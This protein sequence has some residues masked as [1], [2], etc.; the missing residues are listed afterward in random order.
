MA[1]L[2]S[3]AEKMALGLSLLGD[4]G[5]SSAVTALAVRLAFE[6]GQRIDERAGD[7]RLRLGT[8]FARLRQ[9]TRVRLRVIARRIEAQ[10]ARG[11]WSRFADLLQTAAGGFSALAAA[12]TG[13]GAGLVSGALLAG[14]AICAAN[15]SDAA[16]G[17][18]ALGLALAGGLIGLGTT[19]LQEPGPLG[20][21]MKCTAESLVWAS[22]GGATTGS[23]AARLAAADEV[24]ARATLLGLEATIAEGQAR[25]RR[26]RQR[27]EGLQQQMHRNL[28]GLLGII[29][30]D[31]R[32]SLAAI[33]VG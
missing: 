2:S 16:V 14:S 4:D 11:F 26:Q 24:S 6:Q 12:A 31:H 17:Y 29:T 15:A 19:A 10:R 33:G 32:A 3:A 9:Q 23:V 25:A 18:L 8:H 21:A 30:A 13:G 1:L 5:G 7:A 27:L 20:R 28:L 22:R